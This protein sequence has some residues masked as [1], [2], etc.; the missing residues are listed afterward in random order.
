MV[1]F[2]DQL[3][4]L[5]KISNVHVFVCLPVCTY[6]MCIVYPAS[7]YFLSVVCFLVS[8]GAKESGTP[9]RIT[10]TCCLVASDTHMYTECY[11]HRNIHT[12]SLLKMC[13]CLIFVVYG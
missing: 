7:V 3:R 10:I 8:P 6:S 1:L 12:D 5:P 4:V 2:T 13:A 9:H 11:I